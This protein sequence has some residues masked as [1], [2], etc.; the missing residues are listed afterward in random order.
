LHIVE[1]LYEGYSLFFGCGVLLISHTIANTSSF[2]SALVIFIFIVSNFYALH[3]DGS[4]WYF[5]LPVYAVSMI[6]MLILTFEVKLLSFVADFCSVFPQY[7]QQF[8]LS[9]SC[10]Q[11]YSVTLYSSFYYRMK[12]AEKAGEKYSREVDV[13]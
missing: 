6:Y 3:T 8:H 10:L 12:N 4:N 5:S 9:T 11:G 1:S 7:Q 13:M 2:W